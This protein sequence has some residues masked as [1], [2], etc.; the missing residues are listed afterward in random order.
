MGGRW[1]E[2]ACALGAVCLSAWLAVSGVAKLIEPSRAASVVEAHGVV[3]AGMAKGVSVGVSVAEVVV[4]AVALVLVMQNRLSVAVSLLGLMFAGL[5]VYVSLV[6]VNPPS[7]PT[8]CGCGF[9]WKPV[10]SWGAIVARNAVIVGA[11]FA[12]VLFLRHRAAR[13]EREPVPAPEA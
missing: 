2:G 13:T 1:V 4:A 8:G 3:P 10:E 6:W 12:S 7:A 5:L 9:S 11:L